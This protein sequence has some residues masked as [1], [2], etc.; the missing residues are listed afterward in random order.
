VGFAGRGDLGLER[1][2][3]ERRTTT[4]A[5]PSVIELA[6]ATFASPT[7]EPNFERRPKD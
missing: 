7:L 5:D 4:L 6:A 3:R 2:R 1:R